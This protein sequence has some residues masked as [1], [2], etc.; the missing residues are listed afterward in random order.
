MNAL[1]YIKIKDIYEQVALKTIDKILN[2]YQNK[3]FNY[4]NYCEPFA[5]PRQ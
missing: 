2:D 1:G 4:E 3:Y 5:R